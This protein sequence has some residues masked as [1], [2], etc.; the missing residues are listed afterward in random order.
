MPDP[1]NKRKNQCNFQLH[2]HVSL[3]PLKCPESKETPHFRHRPAYLG[4]QDNFNFMQCTSNARNCATTSGGH[5]SLTVRVGAP[6]CLST[7]SSMNCPKKEL[8]SLDHTPHEYDGL[9]SPRCLGWP[10]GTSPP[11]GPLPGACRPGTF[12][13]ASGT[14]SPLEKVGDG[15]LGASLASMFQS[16]HLSIHLCVFI[17]ISR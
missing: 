11:W 1:K 13:R 15:S 14:G 6:I 16:N 5:S 2:E 8:I 17:C 9:G 7:S 12:F 3:L 4:V 10:P